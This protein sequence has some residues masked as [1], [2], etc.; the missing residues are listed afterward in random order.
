MGTSD[1]YEIPEKVIILI[2]GRAVQSVPERTHV[3]KAV[4]QLRPTAGQK[5]DKKPRG[6]WYEVNGDWR[7]FCME[8]KFDWL[9]NL[10][11]FRVEL[12]PSVRLL[13]LETTAAVFDFDRQFKVR[14]EGYRTD[15]WL[16][17][18]PAVAAQY[19]GIEIASYPAECRWKLD[20]Y[21]PWDC[22]SGCLW[23]PR[24]TKVALE[25]EDVERISDGA[26]SPA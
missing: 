21:Y 7:R 11:I 13:R 6:F 26:F 1:R 17:D 8:N 4:G 20:W 15:H 24:N 10:K 23:E 2:A 18:W 22:A 19:D 16:I 25:A 3:G 5:R 14:R 9:T 12:D